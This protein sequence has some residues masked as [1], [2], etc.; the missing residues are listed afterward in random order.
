MNTQ[1]ITYAQHQVQHGI[2]ALATAAPIEQ[3][4]LTEAQLMREE[5][6]ALCSHMLWL[7][8]WWQAHGD[9]IRA[10]ERQAAASVHDHFIDGAMFARGIARVAGFD[11]E[12]DRI[13]N[14]TWG[15]NTQTMHMVMRGAA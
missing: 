7:R 14:Y 15:R 3:D 5:V 4:R 2:P 12:Q 13:R 11:I 1:Q 9:G 8:S 10:V 6:E